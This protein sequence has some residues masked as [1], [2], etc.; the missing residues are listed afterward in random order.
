MKILEKGELQVSEKERK[1]DFESKSK[2]IA[3]IIA[4]KCINKETNRPFPIRMVQS[5]H[6]IINIHMFCSA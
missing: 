3:T 1:E 5:H 6:P 2:E 4:Q